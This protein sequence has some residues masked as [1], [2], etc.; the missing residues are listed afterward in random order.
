MRKPFIAGNWKMF[1]TRSTGIELAKAI[2]HGSGDAGDRDVLVCPSFA[3]LGDVA[4]AV[5]G[6]N[7]LI[8]AQNMHFE[9]EGAFTGEVSADMLLSVSC[10]YVILGHSERRHVFHEKDPTINKK[11]LFALKKNLKP[12]LCVGELLEE[13]EAGSTETV[14]KDQVTSGLREVGKD[15]M[16]SV[17]IAYE[18]VWAI[19][20]GKTATPEDADGVHSFI[21]SIIS[22]LYGREISEKTRILYGGSVKPGNVDE[23]M[24]KGN[25]DGA[26]V[27]GAS[28]EADSFLRV[29]KFE[30]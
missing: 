6:S 24:A 30:S 14:V 11:I 1:L 15:S 26:L 5:K 17:T 21:R 2:A 3:L 13:R 7:V 20:T 29:I 22:E 18:P 23:L 19:G 28:L 10:S 16:G 8:G 12:I 25:I 9:N 4:D 27:G